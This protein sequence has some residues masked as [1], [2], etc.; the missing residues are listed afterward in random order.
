MVKV[1]SVATARAMGLYKVYMVEIYMHLLTT[2]VAPLINNVL[3]TQ[4]NCGRITN[5][6]SK[7]VRQVLR[8]NLQTVD[9]FEIDPQLHQLGI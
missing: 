2:S 8:D 3:Q 9:S 1:H 6:L 5:S 4:A 7:Y